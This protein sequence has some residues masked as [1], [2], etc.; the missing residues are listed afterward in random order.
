MN[1]EEQLTALVGDKLLDFLLYQEM[2]KRMPN[3][4]VSNMITIRH[5]LASNLYLSKLWDLLYRDDFIDN[6]TEHEKGTMIEMQ[7]VKAYKENNKEFIE[8]CIKELLWVDIYIQF[9]ENKKVKTN[10]TKNQE[11]QTTEYMIQERLSIFNLFNKPK[12]I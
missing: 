12:D 11:S 2:S 7:L 1:K 3:L 8:K 10:K 6:Y 4:S 9:I 5:R